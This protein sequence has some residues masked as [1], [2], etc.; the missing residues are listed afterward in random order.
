MHMPKWFCTQ[1][2]PR[3][4]VSK[5]LESLKG[6]MYLMYIPHDTNDSDLGTTLSYSNANAVWGEIQQSLS[7]GSCKE[8]VVVPLCACMQAG[9]GGDNWTPCNEHSV[10]P[11][12]TGNGEIQLPHALWFLTVDATLTKDEASSNPSDR[13]S[14][15]DKVISKSTGYYSLEKKIRLVQDLSVLAKALALQ[16][17]LENRQCNAEDAIVQSGLLKELCAGKPTGSASDH[18]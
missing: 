12:R 7:E 18:D 1:H 13:F 4:A 6:D 14:L 2:A 15:V 8:G 10:F 16:W 17:L 9:T 11:T 3:D 5:I